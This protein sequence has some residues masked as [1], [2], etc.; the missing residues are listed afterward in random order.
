[1]KIFEKRPLAII[2]CVMLGGFSFFA[3]F[4]WQIKLILASL[5][6]LGIGI[7]FIFESLK[8]GRKIFVVIVLAALAISLLLS[9]LWSVC[10]Y[11]TKYY[12]DSV[13]ITA[14]IYDIDNSK[15]TS[16]QIVLKTSK[17]ENKRD[18]HTFIMKTD[19]ETAATLRKYDVVEISCTVIEF[20]E[21]DDGFDGKSYYTSK[22]ISATISDATEIEILENKPDR[23]DA[24]FKGMQ[25]KISNKLKLR[26]DFETGSLLSALIVGDRSDLSGNTKLNF[27]R[28]GI[29][30]I[31]ALSGMHLAMLSLAINALFI[32]L[33]IK[34]KIRVTLMILL[35]IF[36]MALTGFSAS[37]LRSGLMLIISSALFLLAN[38]ADAL[39]SLA[40]SVSI[41][42][43]FNPTAIFDISL[44]LSAFATL[45]VIVFAEL[46]QKNAKDDG[47]EN[48]LWLW[49]KNACLVSVFAISA[50]F[51]FTALRFDVISIVT[52]F[53]TLIF[54]FII[55]FFI[56]AG[57]LLI[58]IGGIIPYGKL[59]VIFSN[60]V[61]WIAES[62]S[63][64]K[65]IY[66]SMN[67]F[68]VKLLIVSLSVFYFAFL[69]LEIKNKKVGILIIVALLASVFTAA[70]I[71]T[72]INRYEDDVVYC[73]SLSGDVT[74]LKSNGEVSVIYSGR[75]VASGANDII[76]YLSEESLTYI[77]NFIFT[78]YSYS[79]IDF[80]NEIID[81]I[82]IDKIMLPKPTTDEELGQ[83]EGLS[84][85]LSG[86]GT[87]MEF[88]KPVE[89][90][91]L[92]VYYYRLIEKSDY[93]YGVSM[94]TV[95]EIVCYEKRITYIMPCDY[96]GLTA[97]AR[98]FMRKTENLIIGTTSNTN[99]Y[100]FNTILPE[101]KNIYCND[102]DILSDEVKENSAKKGAS[103]HSVKTPISIFD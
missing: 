103:T 76:D 41:I 99:K 62:I 87:H 16:S 25:L 64:A 100:N 51:A 84:Y 86:Y 36:Y 19:K 18:R 32:R 66:V 65:F 78:C 59:M 35:V 42:V 70:E 31:L 52:V 23:F 102:T 69:V 10:F 74:L 15:S 58:I 63:S 94:E 20:I 38:K 12:D 33:R 3:D 79:T 82:K 71:H 96:D 101:L 90:L 49:F 37:V 92:G 39:T 93:M 83:A 56:Y 97:S 22:G 40:I 28:L 46:S 9:A 11:P 77:D 43:V 72:L 53:T 95:Y 80:A 98:H 85:L 27:A 73:P 50:T 91:N 75:A 88:Y 8:L 60:A 67:S 21:Y 48:K 55:Q 14:R 61:L 4:S 57:L 89:Y 68:I 7:I 6:L 24:F 30:H 26:T 44:W 5:P 1:M 17:I 29:S 45:G 13:T 54:S 34:K 2:L 47:P 81:G